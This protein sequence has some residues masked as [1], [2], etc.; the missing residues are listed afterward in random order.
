MLK[1]AIPPLV[2]TA[3]PNNSWLHPEAAYPG[4][5]DELGL[6]ARRCEEAG[7]TVLHLHSMA[8]WKDLVDAV[9]SST[10]LLLQCGMSSFLLEERTEI[11]DLRADMVSI[12]A[13]HHDEAFP[14]AACNVL[15]PMEELQRYCELC[16]STG[17]RPEWEIWHSGSVWNLNYLREHANLVRPIITT[18]F[19]G[20]PGGTWSPPTIDEYLARRRLMPED[21]VMTV[22]VM[23]PE[24]YGLL[25]A[26]IANGD[27]VRVGTEDYPFTRDGAPAQASELVAEVAALAGAMGRTV[28]SVEDAHELLGFDSARADIR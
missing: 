22:S 10:S 26:A 24:R 4:T 1:R 21:C 28:A 23:G 18:L 8:D 25:A 6:E 19:F 11:F 9:R 12:I 5:P 20:W 27:H 16:I 17:V 14:N 2:I 3:T 15:H 7:A 13:N